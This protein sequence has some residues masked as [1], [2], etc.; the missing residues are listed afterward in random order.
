MK[1]KR[2]MTALTFVAAGVATASAVANTG[3]I[4]TT[5]MDGNVQLVK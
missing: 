3:T 5:L 1:L 4:E 2:L